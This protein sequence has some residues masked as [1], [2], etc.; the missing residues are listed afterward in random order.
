MYRKIPRRFQPPGHL[1]TDTA[2]T[3]NPLTMLA[4]PPF[5][6]KRDLPALSQGSKSCSK[7]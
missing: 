3:A 1:Y 6:H 4:K 7:W 5:G 2:E